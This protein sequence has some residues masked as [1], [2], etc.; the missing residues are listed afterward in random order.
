MLS[1][2]FPNTRVRSEMRV[3]PTLGFSPKILGFFE[4]VGTDF[5][6]IFFQD[7]DLGVFLGF[8]IPKNY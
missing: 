8:I 3:L 2:D 4:V 5:F 7:L 6:W 1:G